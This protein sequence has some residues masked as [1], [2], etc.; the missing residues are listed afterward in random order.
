VAAFSGAASFAV[1]SVEGRVA[2]EILDPSPEAQERKY[3]F[4]VGAVGPASTSLQEWGASIT[5]GGNA[6][7]LVNTTQAI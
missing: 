7:Q 2:M 3:A 6:R 1:A 5:V 4:K